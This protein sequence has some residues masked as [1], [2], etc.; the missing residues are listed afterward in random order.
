MVR[1]HPAAQL[2]RVYYERKTIETLNKY[3]FIISAFMVIAFFW[4]AGGMWKLISMMDF[5]DGMEFLLYMTV[6]ISLIGVFGHFINKYKKIF[7]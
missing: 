7:E 6:P 3:K 5:S 1:I 2:K 4:I